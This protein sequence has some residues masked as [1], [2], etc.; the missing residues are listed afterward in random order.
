MSKKSMML[1]TSQWGENKSFRLMPIEPNCVFV[2]GIY[3]PSQKVL[4]MI[5]KEVKQSLHM[6]AKLDEQGDAQKLK[7]PRTNG[8]PYPE[9]RKTLETYQEFYISEPKEIETIIEMLASNSDTYDYKTLMNAGPITI[10]EQ[11]KVSLIMP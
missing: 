5:T 7:K 11:P 9:E 8:K 1:I 3:D 10:P 4:A 6:L 2:E